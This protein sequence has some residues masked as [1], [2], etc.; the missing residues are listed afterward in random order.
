MQLRNITVKLSTYAPL[1]CATSSP[2]MKTFSL[3]S[4]SSANASFRASLTVYSLVPAGVAYVRI[5][6]AEGIEAAGKKDGR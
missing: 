1:Y 2:R 5:R 3:A 6:G 4:S